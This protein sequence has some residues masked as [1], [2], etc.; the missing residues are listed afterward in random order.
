MQNFGEETQI[1]LTLRNGKTIVVG[2]EPATL[3]QLNGES[4]HYRLVAEPRASA[5]TELNLQYSNIALPG[6]NNDIHISNNP[7]FQAPSHT[8]DVDYNIRN[9][10]LCGKNNASSKNPGNLIYKQCIKENR[11]IY[12]TCSEHNKRLFIESVYNLF[13][14]K[15]H[16][17]IF[18]NDTTNWEEMDK[19]DGIKKI[20]QALRERRAQDGLDESPKSVLNMHTGPNE[21]NT[22]ALVY[23]H[24]PVPCY[25]S[26]VPGIHFSSFNHS[27][28]SAVNRNTD[29]LLDR[30]IT[31]VEY[32]PRPLLSTP[33]RLRRYKEP[34]DQNNIMRQQ[35]IQT[36]PKQQAKGTTTNAY[37]PPSDLCSLPADVH[38]FSPCLS[39]LSFSSSFSS[40]SL[41][42]ND[43]NINMNTQ[44]SLV[45]NN[46]EDVQMD[47]TEKVELEKIPSTS[48]ENAQAGNMMQI[49]EIQPMQ[50][51]YDFTENFCDILK[52]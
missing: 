36:P 50:S 29:S 30:D 6:N 37:S 8:M 40:R 51:F 38:S 42:S 52:C 22:D 2:V 33:P 1:P 45:N 28:S 15:N 14:E 25:P 32:I 24:I 4:Y 31:E 43:N 49:Q 39:L 9:C 17:F 7:S 34:F 10:V 23:D 3:A 44:S 19:K 13:M 12:Q 26:I 46:I 16:R 35:L 18:N 20:G 27:A 48:T 41:G 21:K 5:A 11:P 47:D